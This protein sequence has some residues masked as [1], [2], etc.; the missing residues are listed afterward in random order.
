MIMNIRP[1]LFIAS[2][3]LFACC[4]KEKKAAQNIEIGA[5]KPLSEV[6]TSLPDA[7]GAEVFQIHCLTCHS[8][9]YIQMQPAFPRKTWEKI[10]DKMRKNFGAAIS[11]SSALQIVNYLETIKG[12]R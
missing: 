10:V 3:F 12:A 11:D 5:P 6:E 8:P 1:F 4:G 2:L 9:R 7:P